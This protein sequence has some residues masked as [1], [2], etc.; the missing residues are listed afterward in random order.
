MVLITESLKKTLRFVCSQRGELEYLDL[1]E[2][3]EV[4]D[5]EVVQGT[6]LPSTIENNGASEEKAPPLLDE[7]APL[8]P[9]MKG[10]CEALVGELKRLGTDFW[11]CE[12]QANVVRFHPDGTRIIDDEIN[13][14]VKSGPLP[15]NYLRCLVWFGLGAEK[16]RNALSLFF[17][18][19]LIIRS[20]Q[21]PDL[22]TIVRLDW[23]KLA[24]L[25]R[26][27]RDRRRGETH[28]LRR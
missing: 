18:D 17:G 21:P 25:T 20:E 19:F 15:S 27:L 28:K 12:Y 11:I 8:A 6:P 7:L 13:V 3:C 24:R 10:I 22:V 9:P 1:R 2:S 23:E 26:G 5:T 4:V 16:S 14:F